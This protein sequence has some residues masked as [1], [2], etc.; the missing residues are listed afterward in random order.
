MQITTVMVVAFLIWCP[1][2]LLL[3]GPAQ[4][5]PAPTLAQPAFHR[6]QRSAGSRAPSGRRSGVVADH[7]RVRPLAALDERL[8]NA[9]AGL[10]R[11]RLSEAEESED[12][13]QHRLHLRGG[14]HRRDHAVRRHDHSG[15]G[16][17]RSTST[18]CW[19]ASRCTWRVR[20]CCGCCFHVFV[21]MVGV[22]ILSGAVNTSMIGANGVMNRVAEDGVL[23]D[24]FRKPHKRFGTTYRI[25]NLIALL[26]IAH[27]RA[28][29][30]RCLPARRSV[31]VRRGV[32]LLPEVAGRAGAALPAAR[33]GIQD[34]RQFPH[35]RHGDSR[36]AWSLTTL[37]PVPGG[38]RQSVLEE[39]R[40]HL[41]RRLHGRAFSC[42]SP[43]PSAST[44]RKMRHEK[45][46]L[47]E[48]NLDHAARGH[49]RDACTARPG[50]RAGG[51]A[52][53][54]Q[55]GASA[56]RCCRRPICAGTTSW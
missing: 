54:Q 25:I 23:L 38:H 30:R 21:V 31:R 52:R 41:R 45:A 53:L 51:G 18:T 47:E 10:S 50:L 14:L 20:R 3:R 42:C 40:D 29:P 5:P 17:R 6:R 1:L 2:T 13:R 43:F 15:R 27:D 8:R 9:G 19:A 22:L 4:I 33:S 12:H 16:P 56:E 35:R 49:R 48:F 46:G 24:W 26:Q 34:P 55:H 39:D 32:E 7:H 37:D 28:E 11:N 36:S 44:R